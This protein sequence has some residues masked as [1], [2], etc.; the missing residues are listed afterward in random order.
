M[1]ASEYCTDGLVIRAVNSGENDRLVTLLTSGGRINVSAKGARSL[2]SR[3]MPACCP[4]VWGN[5]EIRAKG[6][7]CY[8]HDASVSEAFPSIGKDISAIYL[9]Q[10]ICDV[11]FELSAPGED[12]EDLLRLALNCLYAA[13]TRLRPFDQIKG[14]F[15]LRAACLSGYEPMLDCCRRCG[16]NENGFYYLDVMNGGILCSDCAKGEP[17]LPADAA[18]GAV[19]TD[20][21]G[22]RSLL[23]PLTGAALESV[24]YC[25]AAPVKKMLAFSV[26]EGKDLRSFSDAAET[27]LLSHLERGFSSLKTYHEVAN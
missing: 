7:Y 23:V 19:P 14:V 16:K 27:Y 25:T 18:A 13:D 12:A 5:Y 20:E 15:E 22:T 21:F 1:S 8:L 17:T 4:Y 10:Y 3:L 26:G 6:D 2:R 24:R 9:A 11:C